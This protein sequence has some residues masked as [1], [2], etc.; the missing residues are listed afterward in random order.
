MVTTRAIS[1]AGTDGKSLRLEATHC[2][3]RA[4]R[5]R[6]EMPISCH[7]KQDENLVI[8]THKGVVTDDEFFSF[9]RAFYLDPR[10]DKSHNLLVD[11][12]EA[13]STVRSSEALKSFAD[14][15][16]LHTPHVSPSPKI[17]VVAEADLSFG[18][19]RMYEAFSQQVPVEFRV[20]KEPDE[21]LK[22]LGAPPDILD[23]LGDGEQLVAAPPEV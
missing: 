21:A 8:F 5:R 13:E 17:A 6:H 18:L 4:I 22:W 19:A 10:F 7:R 2:A 9:Y 3:R 20:F 15:A 12:R 11:L 23:D 1:D 14:T 16:R